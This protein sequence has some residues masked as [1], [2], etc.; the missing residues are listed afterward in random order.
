MVGCWVSFI[1]NLFITK[2]HYN[3]P[4]NKTHSTNDGLMLGQRRRRW[5]NINASLVECIVSPHSICFWMMSSIC[6]EM[7]NYSR[8][9]SNSTIIE[10]WKHFTMVTQ[11]RLIFV[12]LSLYIKWWCIRSWHRTL[13]QRCLDAKP[14][15]P[16]CTIIGTMLGHCLVFDGVP[17]RCSWQDTIILYPCCTPCLGKCHMT[18]DLSVV[19]GC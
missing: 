1:Y 3:I 9:K 8:Y 19:C 11:R 18:N 15:S 13:A 14:S 4:A 6:P 5:P 2:Y 10:E 12:L 17:P 7:K 16:H